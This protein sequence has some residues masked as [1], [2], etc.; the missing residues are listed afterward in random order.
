MPD[1]GTAGSRV[2]LRKG[3]KC[4]GR[5]ERE[6]G[7]R[8]VRTVGSVGGARPESLMRVCVLI[9]TEST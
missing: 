6:G 1:P 5:A 2:H 4:S 9:A 8:R 3:G 7:R